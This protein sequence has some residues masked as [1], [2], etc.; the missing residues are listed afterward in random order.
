[1]SKLKKLSRCWLIAVVLVVLVAATSVVDAAKEKV[2]KGESVSFSCFGTNDGEKCCFEGDWDKL[3]AQSKRISP[4]N[5]DTCSRSGVIRDCQEGNGRCTV[6]CDRN[7]EYV[8]FKERKDISKSKCYQLVSDRCECDGGVGK[9][10]RL[11]VRRCAQRV[12]KVS[13]K[14]LQNKND[15][16]RIIDRAIESCG[17]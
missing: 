10:S 1:M 16:R 17:L 5:K 8:V 9:N 15:R 7:C 14:R 4:V 13:C 12:M 6:K 3:D 2:Q 11:R